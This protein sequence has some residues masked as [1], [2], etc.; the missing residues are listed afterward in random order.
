[1]WGWVFDFSNMRWFWVFDQEIQNQRTT[2]LWALENFPEP[3]NRRFWVF[4]NP[5][6]NCQVS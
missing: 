2:I 4:Q 6:Q 5:S 3:K 1:M